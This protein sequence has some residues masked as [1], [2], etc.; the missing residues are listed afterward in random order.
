MIVLLSLLTMFQLNA[1]NLSTRAFY[2]NLLYS[3]KALDSTHLDFEGFIENTK[4]YL[5]EK[6]VAPCEIKRVENLLGKIHNVMFKTFYACT[7]NSPKAETFSDAID[8]RHTPDSQHYAAL[9]HSALSLKGIKTD[10]FRTPTHY[11]LH[12][13]E[14]RTGEELYWCVITPL[15]MSGPAK[16]KKE[17][18]AMF[19][20]YKNPQLNGTGN[21]KDSDIKLISD[22]EFAEMNISPSNNL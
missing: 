3:E 15:A 12:Y 13:E 7:K 19:N 1:N 16:D 11:G 8:G 14:P 21:I 17:Y 5:D 2:S 6:D 18:A 10:F 9:M 4:Y 22:D 20:K